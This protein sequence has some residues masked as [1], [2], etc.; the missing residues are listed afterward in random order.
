MKAASGWRRQA[1]LASAHSN[2]RSLFTLSGATRVA[3]T[4]RDVPVP[5]HKPARVSVRTY[6]TPPEVEAARTHKGDAVEELEREDEM[7]T[8]AGE[9]VRM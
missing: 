9:E 1:A 6:S 4:S 5:P 8:H 3:R 2:T 7:M